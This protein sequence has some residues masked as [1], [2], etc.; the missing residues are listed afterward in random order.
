[1]GENS[2]RQKDDMS[3]RKLLVL[4]GKPIG[5]CELVRAAQNLGFF[6]I[7]ADYL[8]VEDS[9]AKQIADAHWDVSTS[10]IEMLKSRCEEEGVGGVLAGVHEFNLRKMAALSEALGLSCYCT[11]EQQD[12]CDDKI[13]FKAYCRDAGLAV[14]QE[15]AEA[16]A[17]QLLDTAYPLAVKPRDGS[18]SRGFTKCFTSAELPAAIDFAKKNS[19]CGEAMIE[20]FIE[21]DALI[22]QYTAHEGELYFCG[23]TDKG[24]RKISSQGAPIMSLQIAP[25]IH[26]KEYLENCDARVKTLLMS[27]DVKEGPIWLELFYAEGRFIVNEIGYR[28]GGSLTYHLVREL[29]GVDQLELEIAQSMGCSTQG[30]LLP[31]LA[32]DGSY[33]IWPLHLRPGKIDDIAGVDWLCALPECVALAQVHHKGDTIE[34]WGSAQQVFAYLHL[35]DE[36]LEKLLALM[37]E[38]LEKVHVRD[39]AGND[40][41]FALFDPR[42]YEDISS[43]PCFVRQALGL[44]K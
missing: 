25:S 2:T 35:K 37:E 44:G 9:P 13:R 31:K 23:L 18:G 5:S 27:L 22:V 11:E 32:Y 19:F 38:V 33:V 26:T 3:K 40:M 1:M 17:L 4:G 15:Y 6:V 21:S 7:V 30:E 41:L 24:S 12:L 8:P 20:E 43:M 28:F 34:A 16:E 42:E 36:S 29:Y 14:A 39:R 10:D